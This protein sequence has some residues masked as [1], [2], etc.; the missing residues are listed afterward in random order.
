MECVICYVELTDNFEFTRCCKHLCCLE[1]LNIWRTMRSNCP[2][3]RYQQSAKPKNKSRDEH[4][5]IIPTP[6]F[7]PI[8]RDL[9]KHSLPDVVN[10][11][12]K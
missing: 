10:I 6:S 12:N 1:C 8:Y 5:K 3:C 9:E 2:Y 4:I 7:T 11:G